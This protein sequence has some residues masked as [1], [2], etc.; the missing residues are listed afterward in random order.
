MCYIDV[1][2]ACDKFNSIYSASYEQFFPLTKVSRRGYRDKK[3]I[4]SGLKKASKHTNELYMEWKKTRNVD[5]RNKYI[6]YK[7]IFSKLSKKAEQNCYKM[8]FNEISTNAKKFGLKLIKY[9][10]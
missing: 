8:K 2:I 4:T 10:A 6:K 9:A 3:W 5:A 1:N 7:N